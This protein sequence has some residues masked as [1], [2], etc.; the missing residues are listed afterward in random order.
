VADENYP[1]D[2]DVTTFEVNEL[3]VRFNDIAG[4]IG[5]QLVIFFEH[6][7]TLSGNM[8]LRLLSYMADVLY[9]HVVNRDDLYSNTLVTIP[10]PKFYVLYNGK[11]KLKYNEMKLS[12]AFILKEEH[13]ALELTA[14]IID[15]GHTK[16]N[17]ILKRSNTLQGYSLLVEEIRKNEKLTKS[18]DHAIV[19]AMDYCIK[20]GIIS[21][22]LTEHYSE[23][24]R[25]LR[26]DHD[27]EAEH[28]VIRN[29]A[30]EVNSQPFL[31]QYLV[32]RMGYK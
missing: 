21:D 10:T 23:V 15:I 12:D 2:T 20:N 26:W 24:R 3:L 8:P 11:Q 30:L 5:N 7:S 17:N 16:G 32:E 14:K 29:E 1:A 6:Q 13:P 28:R 18:R 25:M 9:L 22:F 31:G 4:R 27:E 19:T